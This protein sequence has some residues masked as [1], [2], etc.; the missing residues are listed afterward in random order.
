MRSHTG[1]RPYA[2]SYCN[3]ASPDTYKLKRHLRIHTGEKPY[4]CDVCHAKFTQ[5]N[6]LKGKLLFSINRLFRLRYLRTL[7]RFLR[8]LLRYLKTL[9]RY[10]EQHSVITVSKYNMLHQKITTQLHVGQFS[11]LNKCCYCF[12]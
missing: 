2:C 11:P 9:L 10:L 5:S 3:Y 6:S 4:E 1:E 7:L 8:T 12:L